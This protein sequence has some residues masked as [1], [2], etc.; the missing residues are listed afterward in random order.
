MTVSHFPRRLGSS[1]VNRTRCADN[2][3]SSPVLCRK[4]AVVCLRWREASVASD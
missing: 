3:T 1:S 2:V 4:C